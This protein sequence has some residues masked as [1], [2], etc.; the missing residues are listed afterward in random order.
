[1]WGADPFPDGWTVGLSD[2]ATPN[3]SSGGADSSPTG[4]AALPSSAVAAVPATTCADVGGFT[5][6]SLT[7]QTHFPTQ[8]PSALALGLRHGLLTGVP[9]GPNPPGGPKKLKRLDPVGASIR[10]SLE[11]RE[12]RRPTHDASRCGGL[13]RLTCETECIHIVLCSALWCFSRG[14]RHAMMIS[15]MCTIRPC[16]YLHDSHVFN[17]HRTTH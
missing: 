4:V 5:P 13:R 17:F 15:S 11:P 2:A 12:R 16:V 10:V 14:V 6:L 9:R 8:P 3:T 7:R 1:M